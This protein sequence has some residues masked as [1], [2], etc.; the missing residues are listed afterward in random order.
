MMRH[1]RLVQASR[2]EP[3]M[4][5]TAI[6]STRTIPPPP[7]CNHIGARHNDALRRAGGTSENGTRRDNSSTT[8]STTKGRDAAKPDSR[9]DVKYFVQYAVPMPNAI[10]PAYVAGSLVNRPIA[11]AANAWITRRVKVV[12]STS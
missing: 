4:N 6:R 10:P 12:G 11:A 1:R 8:M 5:G 7:V 3:T 9:P 2:F